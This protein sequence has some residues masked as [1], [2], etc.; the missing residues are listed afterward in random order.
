MKCKICGSSRIVKAGLCSTRQG[1]KQ[2]WKCQECGYT[3]YKYE[4][5]KDTKEVNVKEPVPQ[6]VLDA[7]VK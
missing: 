3:S 2:L 7:E 4:V 6:W 5:E 1:K